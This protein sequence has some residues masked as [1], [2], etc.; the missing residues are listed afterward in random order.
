MESLDLL[1]GKYILKDFFLLMRVSETYKAKDLKRRKLG[2]KKKSKVR[3]DWIMSKFL[4]NLHLVLIFNTHE[5]TEKHFWNLYH[6]NQSHQ[7]SWLIFI[8]PQ[9]HNC[10]LFAKRYVMNWLSSPL[11]VPKFYVSELSSFFLLTSVSYDYV[12]PH[13]NETNQQHGTWWCIL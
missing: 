6:V 10:Y 4:R 1:K 7:H 13:W 5:Y 8:F 2:L 3:I 9:S 12:N 11:H